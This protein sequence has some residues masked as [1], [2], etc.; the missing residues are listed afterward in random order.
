MVTFVFINSLIQHSP[1]KY[2]LEPFHVSNVRR[3]RLWEVRWLA[4]VPRSLGNTCWDL[5]LG[6]LA[7][8]Q[9]FLSLP[10]PVRASQSYY[11]HSKGRKQSPESPP[12]LSEFSFD[13]WMVFLHARHLG[14]KQSP[15]WGSSTQGP[16]KVH[17]GDLYTR[18]GK[19]TSLYCFTS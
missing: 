7:H 3:R 11:H 10:L 4:Q 9:S 16:Q 18:M 15:G 12:G 8:A 17:S 19:K 6:W 14:R 1:V 13:W 5:N 2:V